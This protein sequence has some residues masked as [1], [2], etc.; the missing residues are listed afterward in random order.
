MW[1][2]YRADKHIPEISG[3]YGAAQHWLINKSS[4]WNR[5]IRT[6]MW[7]HWALRS[8]HHYRCQTDVTFDLKD[9]DLLQGKEAMLEVVHLRPIDHDPEGLILTTDGQLKEE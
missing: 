6:S 4:G 1:Y 8:L 3:V 7:R 5:R 2:D 9:A